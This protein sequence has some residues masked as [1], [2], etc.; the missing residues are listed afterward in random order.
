MTPGR[1]LGRIVGLWRYPVKSMAAEPLEAVDVSWHG[2]VGDRRWAFVRDGA[3]RN[4]FPWLTIRQKPEMVSYRPWFVDP[5]NPD[6]SPTYVRSA[7]G[8]EFDVADPA[9]VTE[10]GLNARVIKQD[11]GV[12]DTFT[13]SLITTQSVAALGAMLD[14]QADV[15]LDA[16]FDVQRFRPNLL[17][18]AADDAPFLED[19]WVGSVLQIGGARMRVDMRDGRCAV[20]NVDP[21]TGNSNPSIL[22]TIVREREGRLGVYGTTVQPGRVAMGDVVYL[23]HRAS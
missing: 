7:S 12:F 16:P 2:L 10:L 22:R 11:R 3:E 18:E 19:G 20:V 15:Q 5:D 4:G 6:T 23:E 9:L 1:K 8:C 21:V 14:A 13:L 17:V